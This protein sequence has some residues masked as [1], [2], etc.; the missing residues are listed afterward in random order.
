MG[1]TLPNIGSI[2][3]RKSLV[4][5]VREYILFMLHAMHVGKVA[6]YVFLLCFYS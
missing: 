4:E 1:M 2:E 6:F 3:H 5:R